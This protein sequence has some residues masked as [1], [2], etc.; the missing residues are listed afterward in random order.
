MRISTNALVAC[1]AVGGLVVDAVD[2]AV[3]LDYATY[4]GTALGN[5]ITQWL[6]VRF[7]APPVGELRFAAPLPPNRER[8]TVRA[9]APGKLCLSTGTDGSDPPD[10]EHDEDCLFLSVFAPSNATAESKLPV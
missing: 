6:G 3:T 1:L 5:G 8:G 9:D 10:D 4:E 7:A 2:P